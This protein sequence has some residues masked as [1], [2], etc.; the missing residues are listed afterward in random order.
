MSAL[1]LNSSIAFAHEQ[2]ENPAGN[3][4]PTS[5]RQGTTKILLRHSRKYQRHEVGNMFA[6]IIFILSCLFLLKSW[7]IGIANKQTSGTPEVREFLIYSSCIK[8]YTYWSSITITVRENNKQIRHM[9]IKY[10]N[11][12]HI[13]I[14]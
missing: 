4:L 7:Y 12:R 1:N 2:R 8:I 13:S 10:Y 5:Y 11:D 14:K 9:N 6:F 3:L